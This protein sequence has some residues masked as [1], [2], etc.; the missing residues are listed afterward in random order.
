M[1]G[2]DPIYQYDAGLFE[3]NKIGPKNPRK[4]Q[5]VRTLEPVITKWFPGWVKW[6][7]KENFNGLCLSFGY[8]QVGQENAF[9]WTAMA[10]GLTE[11]V[12]L[13]AEKVEKG[14]LRVETLR[15]SGKW[16][17]SQYKITPAS[18]I[19]ALSD[20]KKLGHKSIWY[21]SRFYRVNLFWQKNRFWIRDIHF[22]DELYPERYLSKKCTE[23][24][25]IYDNLPVM[26]GNRWSSKNIR[27]GIYPVE[28]LPDEST[29][30]LKGKEP[31]VE[32]VSNEELLITWPLEKEG[33]L[34]VHCQPETIKIWC[35]DI[36][37]RLNWGMEMLWSKDAPV[38]IMDTEEK[39]IQ[40][41]HNNYQ[42]RFY[43]NKG[44]F[45]K[46]KQKDVIFLRPGE[47]EIILLTSEKCL[48]M[49]TSH[50]VKKLLRNN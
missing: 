11:Q 7:F 3:E 50:G 13:I 34:K 41:R 23:K 48:K 22:F 29:I 2:S 47:E 39:Y 5:P 19:V 4:W 6:Y 36:K 31:I 45:S 20:W 43:A 26:D 25:F 32:E 37:K 15:D 9:G 17:K 16:F 12:E 44:F 28:I 1:L 8:A 42:Y 30:P 49:A 18:A 14:E 24:S 21:Y 40:Y 27:A 35:C 46:T 10:E 38:P 33:E